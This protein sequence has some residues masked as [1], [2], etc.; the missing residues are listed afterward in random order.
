M[1]TGHDSNAVG[2]CQAEAHAEIKAVT[3]HVRPPR[4]DQRNG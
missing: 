4:Q 1:V 3:V 2:T